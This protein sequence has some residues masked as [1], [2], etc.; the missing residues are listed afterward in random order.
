MDY[1]PYLPEINAEEGI[2]RVMGNSK[3]YFR[4]LGKFDGTKMAA[5]I[6]N[7]IEAGDT[8]LIIQSAHALRGT[9]LNLGFPVVQKVTSEI[10]ELAKAEQE[11]SHLTEPLNNAVTALMGSIE[12]LLE[13]NQ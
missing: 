9:A 7:A 4:L 11:S 5:D 12:K 13:D 8:R 6:V 2:A 3:L 1:T 10:E